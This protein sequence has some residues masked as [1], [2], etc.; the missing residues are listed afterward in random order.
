MELRWP[1]V[2][3]L[4]IIL[5]IGLIVFKFKKR[6][7]N[8]LGG[9]LVSNT[10]YVK[11]LSLYKDILKKYKI[12]VMFI[13]GFFVAS[14]AFCILMLS[15]PA[16]VDKVRTDEYNRD[17]FLCMDVSTSV[18]TLNL[19]IV[20]SLKETVRTLKGERFG[21][22]IFN[23]SAVTIVPL[24]DD[25]DYVE[26]VLD[27]IVT[28]INAYSNYGYS[29]RDLYDYYY[30]FEGTLEGNTIYGP[31]LIGDGMV[32]CVNSF[33]QLEEDSDRTRIAIFSTDND[34]PPTSKPVFT[35][36]EAGRYSKN[37]NVI[38]YGIATANIKSSNLIT[39]RNAVE[40]TGGE[41]YRSSSGETVDS[42]V[43]NIEKTSKNFI[44]GKEETIRMD[45]P[46]V[47]FIILLSCMLVLF[48]LTKRVAY[49]DS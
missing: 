45:I 48:I 19:E 20:E 33:S 47:P 24:T 3:V 31:S 32:S 1:L 14:M 37:H 43:K 9:K 46:E 6:N 42:I 23:S 34:V 2:I 21:I 11:R 44:E 39:F 15:R 4:G 28:S 13:E 10:K 8:Y 35:I 36:E 5:L 22:T 7:I 16:F 18:N 25:Y 49:Y 30:L 40:T 26:T 29:N 17:I 41:L 38:I 27:Q 12:L